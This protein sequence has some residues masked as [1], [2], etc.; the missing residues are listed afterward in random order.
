[1]KFHGFL[2]SLHRSLLDYIGPFK[3]FPNYKCLFIENVTLSC[4][5]HNLLRN[6]MVIEVEVNILLTFKALNG[7]LW[8]S[9]LLT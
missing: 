8:F 7:S 9:L 1:M 4:C 2:C 3:S 5:A 6:V